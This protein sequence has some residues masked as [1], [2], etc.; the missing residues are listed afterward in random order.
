MYLLDNFNILFINQVP[1]GYY[2]MLTIIIKCAMLVIINS[3]VYII[4]E[5]FPPRE[6]FRNGLGEGEYSDDEITIICYVK[7]IML[8]YNV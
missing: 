2:S 1:I 4:S 6:E 8:F 5:E 3:R 7:I